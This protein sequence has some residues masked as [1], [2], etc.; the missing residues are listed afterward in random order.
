MDTLCGLPRTLLWVVSCVTLSVLLGLNLYWFAKALLTLL[1]NKR[2]GENSAFTLG[3]LW[4]VQQVKLIQPWGETAHPREQDGS[5]GPAGGH[6]GTQGP[7]GCHP[8][9]SLLGATE[10]L[11]AGPGREGPVGSGWDAAQGAGLLAPST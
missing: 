1:H 7:G 11:Q 4:V 5:L 8:R 2:F 3:S 9:C 10:E 6:R